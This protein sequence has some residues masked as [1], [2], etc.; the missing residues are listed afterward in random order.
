MVDDIIAVDGGKD[1]DERIGS[2]ELRP[3]MIARE[4]STIGK[5]VIISFA[6]SWH[7]CWHG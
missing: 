4:H 6:C 7:V 3:I 5:A 2:N 1:D